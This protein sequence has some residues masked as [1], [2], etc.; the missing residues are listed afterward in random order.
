MRRNKIFIKIGQYPSKAEIDF[1]SLDKVFSKNLSEELRA[2]LGRAIGLRAHGIGV[3]SFV[4]LRRIFENLIEE[5]HI[6][7]KNENNWDEA[8]YVQSKMTERISILKGHLPIR[9]VKN[10]NLYNILSKGIHELTE[11]EC[12]S[13]FDIILKA[14]EMILREKSD[15][16]EYEELVKKIDKKSSELKKTRNDSVKEQS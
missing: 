10:A 11:D 13:N 1:G 7:A 5:A 3:G 16:K 2:E 9:I 12:L 15:E 14:L 4:Y 6:S 8:K